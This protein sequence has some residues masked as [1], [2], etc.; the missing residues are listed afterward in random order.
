VPAS[1]SAS[2]SADARSPLLET[3]CR[4][5]DGGR[6]RARKALSDAL[7]AGSCRDGQGEGFLVEGELE[8]GAAPSLGGDDG[9]QPAADAR[10]RAEAEQMPI[11][12]PLAVEERLGADRGDLG[13]P[14]GEVGRARRAG[15]RELLQGGTSLG[16]GRRYC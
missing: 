10:V 15:D 12:A 9:L 3:S 4:S 8:E 11:T 14:P 6:E 2:C 16:G 5:P 1:A 7:S 13:Q